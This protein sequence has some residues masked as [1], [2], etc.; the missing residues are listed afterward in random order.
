MI[1]VWIPVTVSAPVFLCD[2][3]GVGAQVPTDQRGPA[4][5]AKPSDMLQVSVSTYTARRLQLGSELS[6][7]ADLWTP[8]SKGCAPENF[9]VDRG[10]LVGSL[11][12]SG[13]GV[14]GVTK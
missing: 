11:E 5:Q 10:P 8:D 13:S 12:H 4:V 14:K 2:P 3:A 1:L 6:R 7:D 9:L